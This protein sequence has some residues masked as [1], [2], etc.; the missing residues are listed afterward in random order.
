ML[1]QQ[2]NNNSDID[3][4]APRDLTPRLPAMVS[5]KKLLFDIEKLSWEK[6][7]QGEMYNLKLD[8]LRARIESGRI[9]RH[10]LDVALRMMP[11]HID[12]FKALLSKGANPDA[13]GDFDYPSLLCECIDCPN[14]R[15]AA[16]ALLK[17]GANPNAKNRNNQYAL[18]IAVRLHV[19]ISIITE[20]L[21]R[22]ADMHVMTYGKPL[23]VI[24][25]EYGTVDAVRV[26]LSRGA[27]PRATYFDKN[28]MVWEN[29]LSILDAVLINDMDGSRNGFSHSDMVEALLAAGVNPDAPRAIL[30]KHFRWDK[31]SAKTQ[32]VVRAW[33]IKKALPTALLA[34][35]LVAPELPPDLMKDIVHR[36]VAE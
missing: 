13:A 11:G 31:C 2:C 15:D 4:F 9:D 26:L 1:V 25:V 16:I 29:E 3:S 33:R 10:Y 28:R 23:L 20:L 17:A 27:D 12:I 32:Q 8:E 24:A 5:F 7:R 22:G 14:H 18:S 36:V 30:Y 34:L 19:D 6:G 35:S 21:D